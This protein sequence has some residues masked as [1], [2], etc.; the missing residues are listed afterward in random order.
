[1]KK[2]IDYL[3]TD[4]RQ[5]IIND[6]RDVA[7]YHAHPRRKVNA[8]YFSIP[9]EVFCYVDFLGQ[10]AFGK[11]NTESAEKFMKNYFPSNYK[12]YAELIYS[13]WRHG[14]VHDYKPKTYYAEY[15]NQ[16]PKKI[17]VYWL[18]NN[19][20][21]KKLRKEHLKFFSMIGKRGTIYLCV[22]NC[23]F[24]DD[25]LLALNSYIKTLEKDNKLKRDCQKRLAKTLKSSPYNSIRRNA[26][27]QT[28]Y[29]QI[30]LAWKNKDNRKIDKYGNT[31]K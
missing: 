19:G 18:S 6:V 2:I 25:L 31:H 30:L 7:H 13:M 1:M 26:S 10:L 14:T 12:N 28:V 29:N 23:Q 27:R 22:N 5:S 20:N 21:K 16:S 8:G 3:K 11:G 15:P 24:V 9:R 17:R 4:L